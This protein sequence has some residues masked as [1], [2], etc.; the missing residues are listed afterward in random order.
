MIDSIMMSKAETV[1]ADI[2]TAINLAVVTDNSKSDTS[3]GI[4]FAV[5]AN[6]Y[7]ISDACIWADKAVF[8]DNNI[9]ANVGIWSYDCIVANFGSGMN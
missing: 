4:D 3:I 1:L 9:F 7:S 8:A 6:Y 5:V 2:G